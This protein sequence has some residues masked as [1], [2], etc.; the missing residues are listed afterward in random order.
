M[1]KNKIKSISPEEV[2]IKDVEIIKRN[3]FA[4]DRGFLI[5]TYSASK[6]KQPS[7]Y[8]Y[9]SLVQPNC[10]KDVDKY[11]HH[12]KQSDRFT[13]VLGKMLVLLFDLRKDSPTFNK[14]EVVLLEGGSGEYKEKITIPNFT[15]IIPPGV[16]HGIKN[17]TDLPSILVNHP[18]CE[19]N[20]E[21]E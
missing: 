4:D 11:H 18:T 6:E 5:E 7:V 9:S 15:I 10:A 1:E 14:M 20:P 21:D 17:P 19:Y 13:V 3:L 2:T 8:S 16:Y 12:Q